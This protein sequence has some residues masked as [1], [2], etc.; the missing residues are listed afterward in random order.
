MGSTAVFG[1][2]DFGTNMLECAGYSAPLRTAPLEAFTTIMPIL[3]RRKLSAGEVTCLTGLVTKAAGSRPPDIPDSDPFLASRLTL[4]RWVKM[5]ISELLPGLDS[6]ECGPP[7]KVE[8]EGPPSCLSSNEPPPSRFR[9]LPCQAAGPL[10][11]IRPHPRHLQPF[12]SCPAGRPWPVSGLSPGARPAPGARPSPTPHAVRHSSS[13]AGRDGPRAHR[14][15]VRQGPRRCAL[16]PAWP[17]GVRGPLGGTCL[18]LKG[19][20][21]GLNLPR[22]DLFFTSFPRSA[23]CCFPAPK[24]PSPNKHTHLGLKP[25]RTAAFHQLFLSSRYCVKLPSSSHLI[26]T[27]FPKGLMKQRPP[28]PHFINT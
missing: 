7:G 20:R 23:G 22:K 9:N 21:A 2:P 28:H 24:G 14:P 25:W 19:A 15:A 10:A 4:R 5:H 1:N 8:E 12:P 3:Q 17:A 11:F 16:C 26:L 18:S 27:I 13:R 6:L